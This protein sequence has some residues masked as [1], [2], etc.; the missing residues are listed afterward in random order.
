MNFKKSLENRIKGW[1]PKEPNVPKTPAKIGFPM[2]MKTDTRKQN[3]SS[4]KVRRWFHGVSAVWRSLLRQMSRGT[5]IWA[6]TFGVYV[7]T[8]LSLLFLVERNFISGFEYFFV[9]T[10]AYYVFMLVIGAGYLYEYFK[11]KA[12]TKGSLSQNKIGE[13][14]Y[15]SLKLGST[16]IGVIGVAMIIP[17]I[18]L[19]L[20]TSYLIRSTGKFI[21]V[22]PFYLGTLPFY[23][24]L[25]GVLMVF[26]S[27]WLSNEWHKRNKPNL[28]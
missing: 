1:L 17:A 7:I 5:K 8:A 9:G 12:A 22:L 2:K 18:V 6:V 27:W 13:G 23:L 14:V 21:A 24:G 10:V 16:I 3:S 20:Y 11:K 15:P 25:F 28:A 19:D 4:F 26:L